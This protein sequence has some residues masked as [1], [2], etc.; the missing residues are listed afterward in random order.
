MKSQKLNFLKEKISDGEDPFIYVGNSKVLYNEAEMTF[1]EAKE[2]C[3]TMG[4]NLVEFWDEQDW[5]QVSKVDACFQCGIQSV[6]IFCK[7][8]LECSTGRWADTSVIVQPNW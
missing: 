3:A 8:F 6:M 4:S 5:G 2:A 1:Y 7:A